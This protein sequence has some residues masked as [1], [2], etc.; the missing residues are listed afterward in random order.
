MSTNPYGAYEQGSVLSS[1]SPMQ[2][3]IALYEGG[4]SAVQEAKRCLEAREIMAR[5]KAITRASNIVA[6]LRFSLKQDQADTNDLTANLSQLY[7][8]MQQRLLEAN[9]KQ[10]MEP[11]VEVEGLLRTMLEGWNVVAD[12]EKGAAAVAQ[13][14]DHSEPEVTADENDVLRISYGGYYREPVE[15]FSGSL[16]Y[17][18]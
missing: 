14:M 10:S 17:S 13:L 6:E 7:G 12:R 15:S 16:A 8:Y 1:Q 2:L 5:A 11:L 18:F 4:I 9:M 3:I